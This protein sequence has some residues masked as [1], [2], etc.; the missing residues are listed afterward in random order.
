MRRATP[1]RLLRHPALVVAV[2]AGSLL[3]ALAAAAYPLFMSATTSGLVRSVVDRPTVTRY[4]AGI[5]FT[6]R[7]LPLGQVEL[8]ERG[9]SAITPPTFEEMDE[10]FRE[11]ASG[12]PTLGPPV[13][14]ILGDTV[15]V[16]ADGEA[17]EQ[18]GRLFS[19]TGALEAVE[20]VA[21]VDGDG[22]WLP[23]LIADQL[24]VGPGDG[25]ASDPLGGPAA[26]VGVDGIYRAIYA[27]PPGG[28]WP[29]GQG[30][31][32]ILSGTAAR[33]R[34]PS[35][36]PDQVLGLADE[37]GKGGRCSGR[38][39]AR[40]GVH[41]PGRGTRSRVLHEAGRGRHP[42]GRRGSAATSPAASGTSSA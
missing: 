14:A 31:S 17:A 21:G 40:R 36:D 35:S 15:A 27:T 13:A 18:E 32:G 29:L 9:G 37:P 39:T 2:A 20:R 28:Y 22:V 6:F 16:S 33:H 42:C 10:P 30:S 24:G 34:S 8:F 11:L 3:L 1:L 7:D 23:D 41:Q 19:S 12:S 38:R 4:G 5:T 25:R 26:S